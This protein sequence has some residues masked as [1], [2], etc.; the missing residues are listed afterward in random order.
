M[1]ICGVEVSCPARCEAG[2]PQILIQ[3]TWIWIRFWIGIGTP[4]FFTMMSIR[5]N[6]WIFS[7]TKKFPSI[8]PFPHIQWTFS[9]PC[10][11]PFSCT[12]RPV[13][14]N[15][16]MGRPSGNIEATR[17]DRILKIKNPSHQ[18]NFYCW[19]IV[20]HRLWNTK[21]KNISNFSGGE[22]V[23]QSKIWCVRFLIWFFYFLL[24]L[25]TT[26]VVF[27]ILFIFMSYSSPV[28]LVNIS[29]MVLHIAK[30][31]S[32]LPVTKWPL[33]TAQARH[34]WVKCSPQSCA[35]VNAF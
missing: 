15:V 4:T 5:S 33:A 16:R 19:Q 20:I 8:F 2:T 27:Y 1:S 30:A 11:R 23:M 6:V 17:F 3:M 9:V 25:S 22:S 24:Y 13:R 7:F 14:N 18:N 31:P 34:C 29:V 12:G 26:T 32:H 35:R 21:A 10:P 28:F